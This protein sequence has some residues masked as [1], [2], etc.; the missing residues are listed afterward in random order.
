MAG[1]FAYESDGSPPA[2]EAKRRSSFEAWPFANDESPRMWTL[3]EL[4]SL[5]R[6]S[7][8]PAVWHL[9]L[10]PPIQPDFSLLPSSSGDPGLFI[11]IADAE[12][13]LAQAMRALRTYLN[14]V[15]TRVCRKSRAAEAEK[16]ET[17]WNTVLEARRRLCEVRGY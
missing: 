12:A 6:P 7:P 16:T 1:F 5:E 4:L 3:T 13:E 17:L 11:R 8:A 9:P 14:K 15:S 10:E 2:G